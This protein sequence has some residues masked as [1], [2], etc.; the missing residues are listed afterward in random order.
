[1]IPAIAKGGGRLVDLAAIQKILSDMRSA[2]NCNKFQPISRKKNMDTLAQLG[3]TWEDVKSEI[4]S[5]SEK[6]YR[7]GPMLDS[8]DPCS[9]HFW[10]FKKRV[11]SEIIYIKFKVL[12]KEDGRV[13]L[14]SFH[15]DE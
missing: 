11:G 4:Y 7:R 8:N 9:D 12:Y 3:L 1:M 6:E 5:L 15:I 10:E 2:I 13:K 14:V